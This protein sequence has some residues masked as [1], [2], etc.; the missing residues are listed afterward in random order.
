MVSSLDRARR[1]A[2]ATMIECAGLTR[3][4]IRRFAGSPEGNQGDFAHARDPEYPIVG[5]R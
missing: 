5:R 4:E 1:E 2:P 3:K